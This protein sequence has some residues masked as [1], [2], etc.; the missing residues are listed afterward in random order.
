M[1]VRAGL[2][3]QQRRSGLGR[4]DNPRRWSE[5]G[6]HRPLQRSRRAGTL[7]ENGRYAAGAITEPAEASASLRG[8]GRA[9]V[10]GDALRRCASRR[11]WNA[12]QPPLLA[13]AA[14]LLVEGDAIGNRPLRRRWYR[15]WGRTRAG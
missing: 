4:G 5:A 10:S 7:D 6:M 3:R 14:G 2:C 11:R 8:A 12:G 1:I 15:D 13:E 9:D